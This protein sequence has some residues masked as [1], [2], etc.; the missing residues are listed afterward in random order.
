MANSSIS[1][2][3]LESDILA[4]TSGGGGQQGTDGFGYAPALADDL[5]YIFLG[6]PEFYDRS[7]VSLDEIDGDTSR[8]V[9]ERLRNVFNEVSFHWSLLSW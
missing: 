9:Y 7:L 8:I 5:A 3:Y 2:Q 6:N 4:T 1:V